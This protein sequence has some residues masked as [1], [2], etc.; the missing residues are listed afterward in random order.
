MKMNIEKPSQIGF[1]VYSKTNCSYCT[2][3]KQ[4]LSDNKIFFLEIQS[5]DYL[6]EDKE[7]FLSFIKEITEIEYRTFPM[8]FNNNQFIGGFTDTEAIVSKQLSFN[9][10]DF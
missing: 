6:L 10:D 5:D 2:K 1:T 4:L 8:V 3:V 9:E 7:A